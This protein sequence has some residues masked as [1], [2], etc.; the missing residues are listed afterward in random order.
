MAKREEWEEG[1]RLITELLETGKPV[2]V[3]RTSLGAEMLSGACLRRNR[4]M[5]PQLEYQL[6]NN[7]GI[8]GSRSDLYRYPPVYL[9]AMVGSD[10][11]GIWRHPNFTLVEQETLPRDIPTF[12]AQAVEPFYAC[13]AG[14][15]PWSHSLLGKKVLVISPF[16]ESFQKQL[17]A[18]FSMFNDGR[19]L[20]LEGQEFVFYKAFMTH[21][22]NEL[23]KSWLETIEIMMTEISKLDFDVAILGCGGYGVPLCGYIKKNL[24]KSAIYIGGAMQLMF[25]VMGGRWENGEFWQQ[26]AREGAKFIRP[27][28]H[29]QLP[30]GANKRIEN[31]CYW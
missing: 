2:S 4:A 17:E 8:Y 7:S 6:R 30:G 11:I 18:G 13:E 31:G 15:R 10:A 12:Q 5:P 19:R 1:N 23:H 25:G 20:F 16:V 9:E 28:P 29:E 24:G 14:E 3:A 26:R 22:G 21:G 27:G